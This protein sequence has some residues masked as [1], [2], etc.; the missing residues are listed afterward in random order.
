MVGSGDIGKKIELAS[1]L[2]KDYEGVSYE[3]GQYIASKLTEILGFE[4]KF[5]LGNYDEGC[6]C[7]NFRCD[8]RVRKERTFD[9]EKRKEYVYLD[10]VLV[11]IFP[12]FKGASFYLSS[13]VLVDK[14]E[15]ERILKF[16]VKE[17]G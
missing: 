15:R 16:F 1:R 9:E 11:E 6:E 14:E 3:V 4:V 5:Q 8:N 7:W 17:S 12:E 10:D 2:L 13:N